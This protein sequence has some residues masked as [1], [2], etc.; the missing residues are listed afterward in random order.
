MSEIGKPQD[1]LV[2]AARGGDMGNRLQDSITRKVAEMPSPPGSVVN[3]VKLLRASSGVKV[4]LAAEI[5]DGSS[6]FVIGGTN[7]DLGMLRTP[8]GDFF[9]SSQQGLVFRPV[10]QGFDDIGKQGIGNC[11]VWVDDDLVSKLR[12]ITF[13][14]PP[15]TLKDGRGGVYNTTPSQILL[16][17]WYPDGN[18]TDQPSQLD[19]RY[20]VYN[21]ITG[22]M[23]AYNDQNGR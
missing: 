9:F 7:L 18:V 6:N 16:F 14:E 1:T 20:N 13:G 21:E 10:S 12:N 15:I 4:D 23:L 5:S 11:Q 22:R 3:Y 17:D 8:D 19:H 2:D